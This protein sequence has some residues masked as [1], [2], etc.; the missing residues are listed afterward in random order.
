MADKSKNNLPKVPPFVIKGTSGKTG[1]EPVSQPRPTNGPP[2]NRNG[3]P[4]QRGMLNAM[5]LMVSLV[6]VGTAMTGAAWIALDVLS[7]GL[8]NQIGILPKILAVGLAYVIGWIVSVFGI[9]VSGHLI[10]PFVIKAFAWITLAGLCFLQ[11]AIILKLFNQSYSFIKFIIYLLM[12]GTGLLALVGFHLIIENHNLVPFSFPILAVSLFHLVLIV[13]HYVFPELE[14]GKYIY[15]WGDAAFFLF[16]TV[17]G[18]LMLA[19]L[20]ILKGFRSFMDRTFNPKDNPFV[21][22]A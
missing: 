3:Q 2:V 7:K 11:V 22:P 18:V 8:D 13:A 14:E 21:P 1:Q 19:H 17:T 12:M 5:I 16:T 6:S 9:R 4:S 15:F 20:G 10:L